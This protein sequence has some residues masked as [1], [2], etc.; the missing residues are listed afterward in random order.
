[1]SGKKT[2]VTTSLE[3]GKK[4]DLGSCRA[5]ILPSV[6]GKATEQILLETIEMQKTKVSKSTQNEFV[7]RASHAGPT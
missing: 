1:M 5:V 4:E 2:N 7:S 3:K 6:S